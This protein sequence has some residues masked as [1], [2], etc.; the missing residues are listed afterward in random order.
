MWKIEGKD[1]QKGCYL[2]GTSHMI[3]KEYFIFPEKLKKI[4]AKSDVL[5]MELAGLP[6]QMEAM[7]YLLLKEGQFSDY[8][9]TAQ[10]D[11]I[12]IW[13]DST[14]HM[15]KAGFDASMSKMKPFVAV[16]LATQM[17]FMGKTESYEMT[18]IDIANSNKIEIQ[19]LETIAQ[20]MSIF[21]NLSKEQQAEMVMSSIRDPQAGTT[22]LKKMEEIY[23]QQD[24]DGLY[25]FIKQEESVIQEEQAEFLDHRN[26]NWIPK[27]K[28]VCGNKKTFIA[29][30]AGHLGGPNGVIRL[31]Q[32]EGYTITPVKLWET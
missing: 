3:E 30:G 21:D 27:I 1:A 9:T 17:Q 29:V 10:M 24:I 20:Q 23:A 31:L 11:S 22:M 16:Q 8:F 6:N 5:V 12:Y 25:T 7:K 15:N 4:V 13:A 19:G 18:L 32:K 2:F 26:L 28:E 14:L